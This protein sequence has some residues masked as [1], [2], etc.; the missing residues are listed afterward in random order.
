MIF[1]F[2]LWSQHAGDDPAVRRELLVAERPGDVGTVVLRLD[3]S[4]CRLASPSLEIDFRKWTQFDEYTEAFD[5]LLHYLG[6]P[7]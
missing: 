3:D 1:R 5:V 2:V 6:S 7:V 4:M